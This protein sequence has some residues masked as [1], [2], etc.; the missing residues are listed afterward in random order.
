MGNEASA[1]HL[2][3]ER[4]FATS[5]V[6]TGSE[7]IEAQRLRWRVFSEE[8]GA[9]L[10]SGDCG[11]DRDAFDD[12]CVHVVVRE[13]VSG[14]IIGTY[15]ILTGE[16][17]RASGGFYSET[18]FNFERLEP[19]RPR[20]AEL[21]RSCVHPDY[22]TGGVIAM[23]WAAIASFISMQGCDLLIGCASVPM[24]DDGELATKI[25]RELGRTHL[26]PEGFRARPRNPLPLRERGQDGAASL[27][28]LFKG[29]L[30]AGA[31]ICGAPHWDE[32]FRSADFM[33]MLKTSNL[34]TRHARHYA[35][36]LT[37]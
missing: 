15:R 4:R 32:A 2:R 17:S 20:I 24:I 16:A 30:R 33:M 8:F 18:E 19:L 27:P 9:T 35:S 29:Y 13:C 22:R 34:S 26:A 10:S 5:I 25:Y 23:L 7:L 28:P 21:G 36:A 1:L 37:V 31:W 14:E 3:P 6:R 11:I 12:H